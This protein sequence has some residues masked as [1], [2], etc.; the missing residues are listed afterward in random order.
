MSAEFCDTNIF[1]YAHDPSATEK[2]RRAVQL[3]DRLW[4]SGAGTLSVQVLQEL[5]VTLTR[6]LPSPLD[7]REARAIIGDLTSWRVI[8]PA[9]A[10]VLTAID[11]SMRWQISFWDAMLITTAAK[12]EATVLWSE[13]L[14]DGQEYDG[15]T[16]RNPF[17]MPV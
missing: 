17:K 2:H 12:G 3:I 13:D 5:F 8:E 4:D 14:N 11:C 7:P 15:V 9:G 6:K 1:V 10:D 16:V